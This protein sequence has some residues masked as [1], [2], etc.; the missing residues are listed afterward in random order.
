MSPW[1]WIA[2]GLGGISAYMLMV[3]I[4]AVLSATLPRKV[5]L[6]SMGRDSNAHQGAN[7][8]GLIG[9]LLAAAPAGFAA[10][11]AI[12]WLD[13]F[14][15]AALVVAAWTA[16]SFGIA[17]LAMRPVARLVAARKENLLFVAQ[18]R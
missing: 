4:N 1:L 8:L 11:A 17:W 9:L 2:L 18:G 13:S 12:L 16:A 7:L 14:P 15:A 3:P 5:N 10:S 6:A